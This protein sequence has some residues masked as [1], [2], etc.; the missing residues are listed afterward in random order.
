MTWK[1]EDWT[2]RMDRSSTLHH[3]NTSRSTKGKERQPK[4]KLQH[5]GQRVVA[6]A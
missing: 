4:H 2:P 3:Q 5:D 1:G 6:N